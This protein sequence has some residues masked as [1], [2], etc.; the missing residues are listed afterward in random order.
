METKKQKSHVAIGPK[1]GE[2]I[3]SMLNTR[4]HNIPTIKS[5]K[6]RCAI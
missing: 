6:Q 4:K 2:S 1:L 3:M 5:V